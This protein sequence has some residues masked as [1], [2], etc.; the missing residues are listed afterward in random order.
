M[1]FWAAVDKAAMQ[2]RRFGLS[3]HLTFDAL[4]DYLTHAMFTLTG[5]HEMLGHILVDMTLPT[6]A[7][8]RIREQHLFG[9]RS[10]GRLPQSTVQD[11]CRMLA[12]S[13]SVATVPM[14]M[15]VQEMDRM[16][17]EW[18]S[19]EEAV[20]EV[21]RNFA[22]KLRSLADDMDS[23]NATRSLPFGAFNPRVLECSASL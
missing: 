22:A 10:G 11:Y 19:K 14:P 7:G 15:L 1:A 9:A 6:N 8:P 20:A 3:Q 5:V 2:S 17:S 4:V 13:A 18:A 21:Y 12:I 23:L 16:A